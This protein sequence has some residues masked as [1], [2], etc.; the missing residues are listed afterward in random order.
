MWSAF[1][2][3]R[4][5]ALL[6][7]LGR[8]AGWSVCME[9]LM[10]GHFITSRYRTAMVSGQTWSV[11]HRHA[12]VIQTGGGG[13][14]LRCPASFTKHAQTKCFSETKHGHYCL[15]FLTWVC[16]LAVTSGVHHG[17]Y[18]WNHTDSVSHNPQRCN[19]V[20]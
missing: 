16:L 13:N 2:W 9:R 6:C 18:S 12:V 10:K 11:L 19:E 4:L 5:Q 17:F 1:V 8:F 7:S 15:C 20:S 14:E 3:V